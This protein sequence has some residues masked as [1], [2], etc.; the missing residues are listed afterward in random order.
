[1]SVV[2]SPAAAQE[3]LFVDRAQ[4][5]GL[6]G[7]FEPRQLGVAWGDYDG[8]GLPD[9]F[10][11]TTPRNQLFHNLGDDRFEEVGQA[12]GIEDESAEA[13][14][15][16][17]G[18]FD[19][20]GDLDLFVGNLGSLDAE[21]PMTQ[22]RLYRNEGGTFVDIAVEAGVA[23]PVEGV[24]GG[25]TS[26]N[27]VDYDRDGWIDLFISNR[28]V[29]SRLYRNRGDGTFA[30]VTEAAGILTPAQSPDGMTR[31]ST[32]SEHGAWSDYDGDGD[33]DLFLCM[34]QP[35]MM[36][37]AASTRAMEM[38]AVSQNYLFRNNGDGTFSDVTAAAG[39]G[40]ADGAVTHSAVWGDYD[41]DGDPD[42]F[43]GSRGSITQNT[44]FNSVLYRNN[45][46]GTFTDATAEAGMT[47][48]FSVFGATWA[49]MNNDGFL[50]LFIA[51]HPSMVDYPDHHIN[52][53][54]FPHPLYASN[55]DGSFTNLNADLEEIPFTTGMTDLG[56]LGGAA[57]A[58]GDQDGDLDLVIVEAMG[59]GPMRYYENL[60]AAAGNH[61]M[62]LTLRSQDTNTH[63]IGAK[64]RLHTP[65]Q[66]LLREVG[67]G[68]VGWGS[69]APCTQVIGLGDG[70]E[71]E[72]EVLWHDGT[73]ESF[74]VLA[75]D[76]AH[77]LV[78]TTG[79][80]VRDWEL[81]P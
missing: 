44:V 29:G 71:A 26:A 36:P 63:A 74:G 80:Q 39:V 46:D 45:G 66:T 40:A 15:G 21:Q 27:W 30:H 52:P 55:R 48:E 56:H 60:S 8:D 18:D 77:E 16:A 41:N 59:L 22:N 6:Q 7:E 11:A 50:D 81:H 68:A 20:D 42:L 24:T 3:T 70:A 64:I 78:K 5:A 79:T 17:W 57:W 23:G 1:V 32:V 67:P 43:V 51:I 54:R 62:S 53:T 12:A 10:I 75:A 19:A 49:D 34:G 33:P 25:T 35:M 61:W 38:P 65:T 13:S 28:W 73:Q 72:V 47:D 69:Q 58:D 31:R 76:R 14:T 37:D 4:E 2:P 9:L